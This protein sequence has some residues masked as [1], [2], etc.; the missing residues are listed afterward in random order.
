MKKKTNLRDR[1]DLSTRDKGHFPKA[2]FTRRFHCNY[3]LAIE[4]IRGNIVAS[5]CIQI[6]TQYKKAGGETWE[7][8]YKFVGT[9]LL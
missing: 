2:S 6:I 9:V 8:D 4:L 5:F 3:F 7:H 1:D